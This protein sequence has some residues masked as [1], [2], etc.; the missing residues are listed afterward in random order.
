MK[1]DLLSRIINSE[2]YFQELIYQLYGDYPDSKI[3]TW[4][5]W[6]GDKII[7]TDNESLLD[8]KGWDIIDEW[9]KKFPFELIGIHP[10]DDTPGK[11]YNMYLREKE[12]E[13]V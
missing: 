12:Y 2:D 3:V 6:G 5:T 10:F 4:T 11:M 7:F 8:E 9:I 13:L 1:T